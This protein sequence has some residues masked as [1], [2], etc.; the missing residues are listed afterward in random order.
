MLDLDGVYGDLA[1]AWDAL[2]EDKRGSLDGEGLALFVSE[3]VGGQLVYFKT[4]RMLTMPARDAEIRR[5]FNGRN[6]RELAMRYG[7][8]EQRIRDIVG[9]KTGKTE[10]STPR[11]PGQLIF[12]LE[13]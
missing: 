11:A 13:G 1:T 9:G 5:A 6:H 4:S 10:A 12:N 8:S 2:P 7:L 3:V